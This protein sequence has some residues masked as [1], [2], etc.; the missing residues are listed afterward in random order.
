M[1]LDLST[2]EWLNIGVALYSDDRA[3]P[4][5]RMLRN[6]SGLKCLYDADASDNA[7]FIAEQ[8]E[9]ALLEGR[10]PPAGWNIKLS[11]PQFIRG[12]NEQGIVD[13]LF[14][15]I[16]PLGKHERGAD[17]PD[18]EDHQHATQNIRAKV[19]KLLS[20]HLQ[21]ANKPPD[22]WRTSPTSISVDNSS[23][24]LDLQ[25]VD[26]GNRINGSV[27]SAWY[28]TKYHRNASLTS[29]AN[30]MS[31]ACEA[32]PSHRNILYLLQPPFGVSNLSED[33]HRSIQSD[34]D[35]VAW[36]VD[37]HQAELK[38]LKSE[39]DIMHSILQDVTTM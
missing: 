34:I 23:I 17:R 31:M 4:I 9:F 33:D 26:S 22:F 38:I 2:Q 18:R 37:K 25:V 27:I 10:N 12:S 1:C 32:F 19:R 39:Q 16:V 15:R 14:E 8:I 11:A 20:R 6:F 36:L 29:G 21:L 7:R 28:K 35:S 30:A 24:Q 5:I 13:E 3:T